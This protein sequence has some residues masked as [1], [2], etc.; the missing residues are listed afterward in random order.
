MCGTAMP[1]R[2]PYLNCP[3]FRLDWG[4]SPKRTKRVVPMGKPHRTSRGIA[5]RVEIMTV[6][7]NWYENFFHGLSL[8]LWRK[9]IS[10]KQTKS[11]ADFLAQ[12][13]ECKADAHLLDVPCGNGRLSLELA[14]RGCRVTGVDISEE[15]IEEARSAAEGLTPQPK[16]I[17]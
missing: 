12:L 10:P 14:R 2:A 9:A 15:F 8:D 13:L 3:R 7:S 5:A 16:F 11:E 17:L 4:R 1:F 6:P